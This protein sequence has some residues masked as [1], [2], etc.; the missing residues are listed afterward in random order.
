MGAW[1][2]AQGATVRSNQFVDADLQLGEDHFE[3]VRKII[4]SARNQGHDG[5]EIRLTPESLSA[6]AP[7]IAE[8]SALEDVDIDAKF[9]GE[10]LKKEKMI[11]TFRDRKMAWL[12][13]LA[14]KELA[15]NEYDEL[16]ELV[17]ARL[18]RSEREVFLTGKAIAGRRAR[19]SGHD[20]SR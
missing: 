20:R 6:V 14:S 17:N 3:N 18:N 1:F 11:A 16:R 19:E 9:Y 10:F 13:E 12:L 2:A 8:I 4:S 7:R 5:V 15:A